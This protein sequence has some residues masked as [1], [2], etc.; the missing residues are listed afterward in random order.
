MEGTRLGTLS[1]SECDVSLARSKRDTRASGGPCP[2]SG[3]QADGFLVPRGQQGFAPKWNSINSRLRKE[4]GT[5]GDEA[6]QVGRE[7]L[8]LM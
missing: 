8:S 6:G 7:F 3:S 5:E 1:V 2:G 4:R